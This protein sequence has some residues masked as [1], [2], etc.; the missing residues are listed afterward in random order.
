MVSRK[1][2]QYGQNF[3]GWSKGFKEYIKAKENKVR[4]EIRTG[5]PVMVVIVPK[6][7]QKKNVKE[8]R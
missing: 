6:K 4:K 8:K 5:R 2:W 7:P 3:K 1:Y